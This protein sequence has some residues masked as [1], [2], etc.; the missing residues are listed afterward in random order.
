MVHP[1]NQILCLTNNHTYR[2]LLRATLSSQKNITP[3]FASDIAEATYN[4][5]SKCFALV[6]ID[7]IFAQK[8]SSNFNQLLVALTSL[9][10]NQYTIIIVPQLE[11]KYFCRYISQGF[12]YIVDIE[13]M[14]YFLPAVL[15]HME[16]FK[17]Q[18]PPPQEITFKG[19]TIY[20]QSN[21]LLYRKCKISA[22]KTQILI[23]LFLIRNKGY[24]P[25]STIQKY[26]ES[27]LGTTISES[28]VTVN[29][30]R[31]IKH[32]KDVTGLEIIKNRYGVG[33]YLVL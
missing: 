7:E 1:E 4:V 23:L 31:M 32:V 14:R 6:I 17:F 22:T 16:E 20:P 18:R 13:V 11:S 5:E 27:A 28:N 8:D 15:K 26:L 30:Y 10:F 2:E 25:T 12:T 21:T 3:L 19:L 9:C 29:I 24:T 33:Y